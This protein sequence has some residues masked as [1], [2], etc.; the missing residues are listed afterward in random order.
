MQIDDAA[1]AVLDAFSGAPGALPF[2]AAGVR[3]AGYGPDDL[4][5]YPSALELLEQPP[6]VSA[7]PWRQAVSMARDVGREAVEAVEALHDVLTAVEEARGWA[8]EDVTAVAP[9][10]IEFAPGKLAEGVIPDAGVTGLIGHGGMGKSTFAQ[11]VAVDALRAGRTVVHL[12]WEQGRDI[13]IAKYRQL[14][15]TD[16]DL[17]RLRYV[18]TPSRITRERLHAA[19]DGDDVLV[20]VDSFAKAAAAAGL[21]GTDWAG[22]GALVNEL[23]AFGVEYGAPVLLIDHLNR[24]GTRSTKMA[25]GSHGKYDSASASWTLTA[26]KKFGPSVRGEILLVNGKAVRVG[27]LEDEVRYGIGGDGVDRVRIERAAAG[28]VQADAIEERILSFLGDQDEP[29]SKTA[30]AEGVRG[31]AIDIRS[32]VDRLEAAGKLLAL[33][34]SRGSLYS[35]A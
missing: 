26:T 28:Q 12:D 4:T 10:A 15:A 25:D 21:S 6:A 2:V 27:E 22:H 19:A 3:A 34:G 16:E 30:I 11:A 7:R 32:A 31:K 9:Y 35:V 13:A 8:F 29:A 20:L 1:E 24:E 14:D 33:E 17:S 18:W 23:N 5:G